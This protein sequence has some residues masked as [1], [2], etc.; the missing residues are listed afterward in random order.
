MSLV[1]VFMVLL[2]VVVIWAI[3]QSTRPVDRSTCAI[4]EVAKRHL[5]RAVRPWPR[6]TRTSTR[7]GAGDHLPAR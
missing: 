6:S 4:G 7:T 2:V 1:M 5:G 3:T